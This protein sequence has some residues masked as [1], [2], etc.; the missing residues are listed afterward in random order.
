MKNRVLELTGLRCIAVTMVVLGH[1]ERTLRDGYAGWLSPLKLFANGAQGVLIFFVLSGFLITGL[2]QKE[3]HATGR[4]SLAQFYMRRVLRIW[5]ACYVFVFTIALLAHFGM[6]DINWRQI[7]FAALHVWN[8][9]EL[10][11]LGPTNTLHLD[12]SW[13]LGHFWSLA[14][15]EQ[16]YWFWPPL[17][18]FVLRRKSDR[19]L[20]A[21][22]LII[23]LIRIAS[24]VAAP[25]LR[26]QLGMMLHTGVD[27]ILIGC[28]AALN[29]EKI[30]SILN[31]WRY[32]TLAVTLA[33]LFLFFI[34]P[35]IASKVGGYW[36]ATYGATIEAIIVAIL[37]IT[38]CDSKDFWLSRILRTKP[39]VFIGTISFS[40]YLWQQLFNHIG[41][42]GTL[43]FPFNILQALAV[44]TLSYWIVETPFLRLKD[45]QK[46]RESQSANGNRIYPG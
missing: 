27:P 43:A 1:A 42:P 16:F 4:I 30:S 40:L 28:Y 26:G 31:A 22:I 12:G 39:F 2:L 21:I 46:A 3:H 44:A 7:A 18:I 24:Y 10:L 38:I 23:P 35:I 25:G 36:S 13:Y 17:L 45:R 14:L 20:L 9:S 29:R 34:V 32:S 33:T 6:L 19:L 11:G 15:E 37:I 5:P 41:A 8:Y